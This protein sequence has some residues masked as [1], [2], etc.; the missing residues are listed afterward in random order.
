MSKLSEYKAKIKDF[1]GLWSSG[2]EYLEANTSGST[3]TP[4]RILLPRSFVLASAHRSIRHFGLT[5]ESVVHLILSVEYIAGKMAIIRALE[6]GAKLSFELPSSTPLQSSD[7]P[8]EITLL[9]AVGAQIESMYE[10]LLTGKLPKIKHLLLGGAP[11][12]PEM[13]I[14]SLSL[15]EFVWESY[16]MTE[17]ASHIALRPVLP[18]DDMSPAPFTPMEGIHT[19]VDNRKCLVIDMPGYEKIVT[20]DIVNILSDGQ[21]N[22]IGRYDNVII[23]GGIKIIPEIVETALQILKCENDYYV[24]SLPHSK[25]GEELIM[26]IE[27]KDNADSLSYKFDDFFSNQNEELTLLTKKLNKYEIPKKVITVP[28]F[29]RTVTG[30]IIR[31]KISISDIQDLIFS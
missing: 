13:R 14:K 16:G 29:E 5:Q 20:N 8:A 3:G 23:S 10:L 21:F 28:S 31:K 17:T 4:K 22:I 19:S 7:T 27:T 24:T 6:S 11:L 30:K 25:W 12:T 26:V 18:G 1:I 2:A 15:A 9:S